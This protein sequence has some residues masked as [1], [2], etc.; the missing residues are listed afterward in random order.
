MMLKNQPMIAKFAAGY[1]TIAER[2]REKKRAGPGTRQGV[3]L[4]STSNLNTFLRMDDVHPTPSPTTFFWRLPS[5]PIAA[6]LGRPSGCRWRQSSV[7]LPDGK[8]PP[9]TSLA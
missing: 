2:A 3:K 6:G 8:V 5:P 1:S 4:L 9:H 7:L